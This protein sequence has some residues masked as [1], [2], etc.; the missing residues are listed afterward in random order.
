MPER[1]PHPRDRRG[2]RRRAPD[3]RPRLGGARRDH[4]GPRRARCRPAPSWSRCGRRGRRSPS[5]SAWR[6]R[7]ARWPTPVE[8]GRDDLVD[9]AGH[10]RR[11]LDLQRLDHGGAGRRGRR[12]RGRQ[13]RQPLQ[14]QPLRLRRPARGAR[15]RH[16]ARRPSR[17]ARC[18]DEVGFGFMFAP[19]HHAAMEHVVPVRK[20]LAVRTIFNFLGPLTNPAGA[21]RQLLGVSDRHYQETIAEALVGLGS[22]RALVVSRRG[23]PRRALV[24]APHAGDRGQRTARTEEWFVE[25]G[26]LRP[27]RGRARGR[28][29]RLA[30]GERRG[31]PRG[32]RR[33]ARARAA[34]S[35]L[36]NAGAA[37]Y[38]GGG[39]EDLAR[40][41]DA[42]R[43]RRSTRAR[44][45]G[46]RPAGRSDRAGSARLGFCRQVGMIEQLD[47]RRRA[48][49]SRRRREQVPAGGPRGAARTAAARTARSTRRW[50]G[51]A[52]R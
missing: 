10:R 23:R 44:R 48:R 24:S 1:D 37:I 25:P 12:L 38:V 27:R 34:T 19:R 17:S 11:P 18:I 52:S 50:S 43:A 39:A 22:E 46:A 33:R 35:S 4:G 36:L 31:R 16:R 41:V 40:G 5:W 51:P 2:L 7:C 3:R 42:R 29:R 14:H 26:R 13:A 45:G 9:T 30:G 28:R 6:G 20:E 21:S 8:T 49:A 15:R 47:R 32:A